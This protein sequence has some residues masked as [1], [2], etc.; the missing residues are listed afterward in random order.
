VEYV[1]TVIKG[2]REFKQLC[3]EAGLIIVSQEPGKGSHKKF[4]LRA[5][6]GRERRY[7][8]G[9]NVTDHRVQRNRLADLKRFAEGKT[10]EST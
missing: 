1:L 10:N 8:M 6:D 3:A 7:T 4:L 2:Q 9:Q 5:P